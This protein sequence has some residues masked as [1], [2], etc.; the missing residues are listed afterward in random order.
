LRIDPARVTS[1]VRDEPSGG[2]VFPHIYGSLNLDAVVEVMVF[3]P[4]AD[5]RF[6]GPAT[7]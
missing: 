3:A 2:D 1:E 4:G 5:G 7:G 6:V